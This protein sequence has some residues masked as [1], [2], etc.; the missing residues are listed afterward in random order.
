MPAQCIKVYQFALSL[1]RET[2]DGGAVND[3]Y[4]Q[5]FTNTHID[6]YLE[7]AGEDTGTCTRETCKD[8]TPPSERYRDQTLSFRLVC[9]NPALGEG[10]YGV[11]IVQQ[12]TPFRKSEI[13]VCEHMNLNQLGQ[14]LCHM[15]IQDITSKQI[16]QIK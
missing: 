11:R 6:R 2:N 12:I 16:M 9:Y 13:Q 15:A 7:H 14:N 5:D 4:L 10:M 3:K 8:A 1:I